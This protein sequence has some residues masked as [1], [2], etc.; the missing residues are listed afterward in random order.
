MGKKKGGQKGKNK[1][2]CKWRRGFLYS[3]KGWTTPVVSIIGGGPVISVCRASLVNTRKC[4]YSFN[5]SLRGY[6]LRKYLSWKI[7]KLVTVCFAYVHVHVHVQVCV[8]THPHVRVVGAS[9]CT[10]VLLMSHCWLML[11]GH[12]SWRISQW[13]NQVLKQNSMLK[14]QKKCLSS[15]R[16]RT[17]Q[18]SVFLCSAPLTIL[19]LNCYYCAFLQVHSA[20][21]RDC[22]ILWFGWSSVLRVKVCFCQAQIWNWPWKALLVIEIP[23]NW[24][25]KPG[26]VLTFWLS[27]W[28]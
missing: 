14:K 24:W 8:L 25:H 7:V 21:D 6:C 15:F 17:Y 26:C 4:I 2:D 20:T 23:L 5:P 13:E 18:C 3:S 1:S 11:V 16:H 9:V 27:W 12:V 22:I 19:C 28:V 10:H